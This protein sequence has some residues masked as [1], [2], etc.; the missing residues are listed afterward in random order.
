VPVTPGE[1]PALPVLVSRRYGK[2]TVTTLNAEGLW[3]WDFFPSEEQSTQMYADFWTGLVQWI[4]TYSDFLPGHEWA[5]RLSAQSVWPGEPVKAVLVHR[6]PGAGISEPP[7]V[8][9]FDGGDLIQE[10]IPRGAGREG[11]WSTV[12]T[13]TKPGTYRVEVGTDSREDRAPVL[14]TVHVK[15]LPTET[16]DVSAHPS[17]LTG[18]AAQS[19]G[20]VLEEDELVDLLGRE[21][22]LDVALGTGPAIWDTRWDRVWILAVLLG[23]LGGEWFLR[24]RHGLL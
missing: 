7:P 1:T 5:L 21:Q 17:L 3:Q 8:K 19:G 6:D 10:V 20:T 12:F 22:G 14:S 13:L 18:L 16:E 4:A 24:R 2:G 15:R 9:V 23:L 11:E